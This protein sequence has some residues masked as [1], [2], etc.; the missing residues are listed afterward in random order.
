MYEDFK[1]KTDGEFA[2][3]L[4]YANLPGKV[5]I[6][7]RDGRQYYVH[8]NPLEL[9]RFAQAEKTTAELLWKEVQIELPGIR[10]FVPVEDLTP[11]QI[12]FLKAASNTARMEYEKR[13][14]RRWEKVSI[15]D[16]LE[17][18][19]RIGEY[20]DFYN[21]VSEMGYDDIPTIAA[22]WNPPKMKKLCD[23]IDKFFQGNISIEWSDEWTG[24]CN[25]YKAV[26][27]SADSYG[28]QTSWVWVSDCEILCHECVKKDG[29]DDVIEHYLNSLNKALPYWMQEHVEAAGFKC[30]ESE[31][32]YCTRFENGFHRGQDDTPKKCL[33]LAKEILPYK[34]DHLFLLTD[35]GQFDIHWAMSVRKV[36]VEE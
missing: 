3:A 11:M 15:S 28:W 6:I 26:R 19:D 4:R 24:C 32:S 10:E 31:E 14:R 30:L 25:C 23:W 33:K 20:A 9:F 12:E 8:N 17:Y 16:I 35:V 22:N 7:G 29:A 27:T 34:F 18:I 13:I 1:V 36:E 21:G 2:I 5:V